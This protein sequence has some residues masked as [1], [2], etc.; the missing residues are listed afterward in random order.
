MS[1]SC[2]LDGTVLCKFLFICLIWVY[3]IL[4]ISTSLGNFRSIPSIITQAAF[5]F[6][7]MLYN[8]LCISAVLELWWFPWV[9]YFV[10]LCKRIV[11]YTFSLNCLLGNFFLIKYAALIEIHRSS[12]SSNSSWYLPNPF[13]TQIQREQW[14]Y[15]PFKRQ[16]CCVSLYGVT[17]QLVSWHVI[18][19]L[20]QPST[21]PCSD[22]SLN[23]FP[24]R[25]NLSIQ[26]CFLCR[27]TVRIA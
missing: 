14:M 10:A 20:M 27:H 18:L 15:K 26:R 9:S 24:P 21:I 12:F 3:N 7:F 11:V 25:A 23:L 5:P 19:S 1:V 2:H 16:M 4:N 6:S 8:H 17:I 22:L 13:S